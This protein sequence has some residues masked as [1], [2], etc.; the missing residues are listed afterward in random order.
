MSH[1]VAS[2]GLLLI[3]GVG[4]SGRVRV[5]HDLIGDDNGYPELSKKNQRCL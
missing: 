5:G 3:T 1:D 4:T 2:D